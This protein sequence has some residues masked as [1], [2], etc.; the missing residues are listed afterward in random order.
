MTSAVIGCLVLQDGRI[1]YLLDPDKLLWF[2][3]SQRSGLK[4]QILFTATV[5]WWMMTLD[6]TL[7]R[8]WL[9]H[10]R[11]LMS[12]TGARASETSNVGLQGP[13]RITPDTYILVMN[14]TYLL[15]R[16]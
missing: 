12:R 3:W 1:A 7:G 5:L 10:F 8:P 2:V 9:R 14:E 6:G 15:R 4:V 16:I 11:T 13:R